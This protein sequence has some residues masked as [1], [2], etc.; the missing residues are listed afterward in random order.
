MPE[1]PPLIVRVP[2]DDLR[3]ASLQGL[4]IPSRDAH[5][6]LERALGVGSMSAA[7]LAT[8]FGANGQL[9][10]VVKVTLPGFLR[11][12]GTAAA[13]AIRKEAVALGRLSS[14][15][16]PNPFVVRYIDVGDL[17]IDTGKTSMGLPWIAIEYVH[18][19]AEGTTLTQR[20]EATVARTGHAFEPKRAERAIQCLTSGLG[21]IHALQIVHR[22]LKPENVL[23]CGSGVDEILKIADFGIARSM[24]MKDTFG[25]ATLGTLGYAPPEQNGADPTKVGPWSDVYALAAV[26]YLLLTGR[27][28]FKIHDPLAPFRGDLAPQTRTGVLECPALH[29]EFRNREEV[30]QALDRVFAEATA[31][32]PER[33]PQTAEVLAWRILGALRLDDTRSRRPGSLQPVRAPAR[34]GGEPELTGWRWTVSGRP[35]ADLVVRSVAWNGDGRALAA[36]DRGLAYWDGTQ[37]AEVSARGFAQPHGIRFVRKLANN[38]W[39]IGG[40]GASLA[41]FDGARITEVVEGPEPT[42]SAMHASGDIDDLAV[43]VFA[44]PGGAPSLY[45]ICGGRWLEPLSLDGVEVVTGLSR[46]ADEA[47]LVVGRQRNGAAW[48]GVHRPLR[49]RVEPFDTASARPWLASA[50]LTDAQ[51]GFACGMDGRIAW[52]DGGKVTALATVRGGPALA[53]AAIDRS[54]RAWVGGVGALW[55]GFPGRGIPMLLAWSDAQFVA[56]F[57]SIYAG[58]GVVFAMSVDGG[59]VEGRADRTPGG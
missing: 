41:R 1:L 54:E 18:G 23:C 24:G 40:D 20:V 51:L 15:V 39:L 19:G 50:A 36:T 37:W 16:P 52:V 28:Y 30:C 31:P 26:I 3:L 45:C 46:I 42:L 38:K 43:F 59:V 48:M 56:P 9:P 55:G 5:Y 6:R 12:A 32:S 33:R 21:A 53:A 57:G 49:F 8:R 34:P 11:S 58:D 7:F 17:E 4:T 44:E 14:V 29:P 25:Y 22:D 10:V 35:M 27:E 47:W 13:L 2:A